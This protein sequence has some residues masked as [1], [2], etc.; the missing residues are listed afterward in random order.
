MGKYPGV[1]IQ[2][3]KSGDQFP[4]DISSAGAIVQ[5]AVVQ[6]EISGYHNSQRSVF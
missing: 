6:R 4:W 1:I 5:G 3:E 2:G